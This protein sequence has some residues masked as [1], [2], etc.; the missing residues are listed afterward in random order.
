MDRLMHVNHEHPMDHF[1]MVWRFVEYGDAEPA[2]EFVGGP[3]LDE[4][5]NDSIPQKSAGPMLVDCSRYSDFGVMVKRTRL[6]HRANLH[7]LDFRLVGAG[8]EATQLKTHTRQRRAGRHRLRDID[9]TLTNGRYIKG[10]ARFIGPHADGVYRVQVTHLD[11]VLG[12]AEFELTNC[13][14]RP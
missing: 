6:Y 11:D 9:S 1:V 3:E 4:A 8:G 7:R 5:K 14:S 13:A 12:E 2:M 10:L